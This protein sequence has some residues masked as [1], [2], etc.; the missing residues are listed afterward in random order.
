MDLGTDL[1][2]HLEGK[3]RLN[4][5]QYFKFSFWDN[6]YFRAALNLGVFFTLMLFVVVIEITI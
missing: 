1:E 2:M 6:F 5:R 4:S 3:N